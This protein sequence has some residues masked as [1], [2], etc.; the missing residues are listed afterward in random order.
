MHPQ[1]GLAQAGL[2]AGHER[3]KNEQQKS[4]RHRRGPG[5]VVRRHLA[6]AGGLRCRDVR[7]ERPDRRQAQRAEGARLHASTSGRPSSRCRTSSSGCSSASGKKMGDYISIRAAAAA[8]AQ[9]FRGRQGGGPISRTGP[10]GRGGAQGRRRP[11]AN[12]QRFLKYSADL[13]DL[14][15]AGYFEQGLDNCREFARHLRAC[16]SFSEVRP[17]PHD[18]RRRE[19]VSQDAPHAGHL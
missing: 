3:R 5:R 7:E 2:E 19:A 8:L 11:P 15:N 12:V 4:H 14:V 18:A 13:Y 10:D 16:G 9:F 1:D 6:G 17:V